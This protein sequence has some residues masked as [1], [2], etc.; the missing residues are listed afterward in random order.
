MNNGK[1]THSERQQQDLLRFV[2]SKSVTRR[3]FIQ[4]VSSCSPPRQPGT[5]RLMRLSWCRRVLRKP[6]ST[7]RSVGP[8]KTATG[9]VSGCKS[10]GV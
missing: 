4:Y 8:P 9:R 2:E 5:A 6:V 1:K 7:S 3:D 10:R